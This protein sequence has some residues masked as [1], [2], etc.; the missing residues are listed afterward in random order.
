MRPDLYLHAMGF[1]GL[2]MGHPLLHKL[3]PDE[4]PVGR[5]QLL[6]GHSLVGHLLDEH[7]SLNGYGSLTLHPLID[8][9]WSHAQGSGEG[10]LRSSDLYGS[11]QCA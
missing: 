11:T 10:S 1:S 2:A 4:M 7:A 9:R 3:R 5:P 8:D 6:P